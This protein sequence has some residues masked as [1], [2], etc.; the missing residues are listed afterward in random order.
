[1][2]K[3]WAEAAALSCSTSQRLCCTGDDAE[4]MRLLLLQNVV[5][6]QDA[7]RSCAVNWAARLFPFS[8]VPARYVCVLGAGDTKVSPL[9]R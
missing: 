4:K 8:D 5:S 7:A 3:G 2:P 1:M 9:L 6:Q